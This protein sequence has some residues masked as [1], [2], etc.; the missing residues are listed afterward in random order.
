LEDFGNGEFFEP[1]SRLPESCQ[2]EPRLNVIGKIALRCD[3]LQILSSRL[4]MQQDRR[5]RPGIAVQKDSL[6]RIYRRITTQRNH[7]AA[8][9]SGG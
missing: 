1:L 6:A 5:A 9:A 7:F 4:A 8:H 3:V 2:H